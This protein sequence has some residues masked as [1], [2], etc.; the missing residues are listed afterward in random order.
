MYNGLL[1]YMRI[2]PLSWFIFNTWHTLNEV[3]HCGAEVSSDVLEDLSIFVILCFQKHP[4][5]IHILQE[6][7]T[8]S[9]G[10]TFKGSV[11][12]ERIQRGKC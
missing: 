9:K 5:L 7:C 8:Q 12:T 6:Q 2:E 4:G 10:V 1:L 11:C 3:S